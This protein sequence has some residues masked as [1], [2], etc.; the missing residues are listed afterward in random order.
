MTMAFMAKLKINPSCD[1]FPFT[2]SGPSSRTSFSNFNET[3]NVKNT[4]HEFF[5]LFT[6]QLQCK[7]KKKLRQLFHIFYGGDFQ[8]TKAR[9]LGRAF[10]RTSDTTKLISFELHF[11]ANFEFHSPIIF[12]FQFGSLQWNLRRIFCRLDWKPFSER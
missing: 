4:R 6:L 8:F 10:C 7:I 3:L 1:H 5:I 2:Y 11:T 9:F 12:P